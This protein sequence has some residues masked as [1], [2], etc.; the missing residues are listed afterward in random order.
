MKALQILLGCFLVFSILSFTAP[1]QEAPKLVKEAFSHKFPNV[2]NVK[3]SQEK[4]TEWEAEF[5]MG[6]TEYSANFSADGTWK[7]TEHAISINDVPV[8]VQTS[9]KKSYPDYQIKEVEISETKS[10]SVYEFEIKKG[11]SSLE[12]V[13]DN[14]GKIVK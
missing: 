6:K 1:K 4:N 8:V 14:N 11:K 2:K 9:L 5:K 10:G 7:E 12:I 3:W 13:F